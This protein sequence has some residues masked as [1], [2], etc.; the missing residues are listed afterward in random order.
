[1]ERSIKTIATWILTLAV[2]FTFK[3]TEGQDL[4]NGN[5]HLTTSKLDKIEKLMQGKIQENSLA[6]VEYILAN[7]HG[8][9]DHKAIGYLNF[10]NRDT[11]KKRSLFRIYCTAHP[12]KVAATLLLV[13]RGLLSIDDPLS[14]Y[15]PEYKNMKVLSDDSAQKPVPAKREIT[16][17]DLLTGQSGIGT[18]PDF[19]K[20]HGIYRDSS[21]KHDV[22]KIAEMPLQKQPGEG[23]QYGTSLNVLTYLIELISETP[24]HE[25]L[26]NNL[27]LPLEMYDT[28][29]F[30][31]AEKTHRF[32]SMYTYDR[33]EKKLDLYED[34]QN[35][36]FIKEPM[37]YHG[38]AHIIS[39]PSNYFNFAEMMLNKGMFR[40]KKILSP[41]YI[42][43]MITNHLPD[44]IIGT[45]WHVRDRGWGMGGWVDKNGRYGKTGGDNISLFWLDKKNEIIGI[46]FHNTGGNYSIL[47]DFMDEVYKKD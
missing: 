42:N 16:I 35:S 18:D 9:I 11:L 45:N 21:L 34:W 7:K 12:F 5:L 27:L 20:M 40:G 30:I 38:N 17:Y 31:P 32:G 4:S 37:V 26:R 23:F 44:S 13:D 25:F 1:M 10:D 43:L 8:I 29:F 2:L 15:I 22:L 47:N 41:K 19:F 36:A 3:I 33:K 24:Y 14:K 39:T 28:D 6:G 46:I